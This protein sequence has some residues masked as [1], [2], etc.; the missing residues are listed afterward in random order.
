MA[1][2]SQALNTMFQPTKLVFILQVTGGDA[3]V[4]AR[5]GAMEFWSGSI[6]LACAAPGVMPSPTS[7]RLSNSPPSL[8]MHL[9]SNWNKRAVIVIPVEGLEIANKIAKAFDPDS[10]GDKS[11]GILRVGNPVT[12]YVCN[13]PLV[14]SMADLFSS[15]KSG[16]Y[17]HQVC[18]Q[19]Y[20]ARW[21]VSDCPTLA[22]CSWFI[23]RAG[24]TICNID[25]ELEDIL[26]SKS[27][28]LFQPEAQL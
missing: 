11:F 16:E 20:T 28:E 1:T 9:M 25:D 27:L 15:I 23:E 21:D 10:G 19:D 5:T 12:H 22:E 13:T 18:L 6:F 4:G 8:G 24:I 2:I 14:D 3:Y 17:L 26:Q 7:G